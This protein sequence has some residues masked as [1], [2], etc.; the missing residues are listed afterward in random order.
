MVSRNSLREAE[1]P[2]K[3]TTIAYVL[4]CYSLGAGLRGLIRPLQ[5]KLRTIEFLIS[6]IVISL[7][8]A[9]FLGLNYNVRIRKSLKT[10]ALIIKWAII[11][12]TCSLPN[13]SKQKRSVLVSGLNTLVAL[14]KGTDCKSDPLR[15][16]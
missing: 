10:L 4:F 7:Q 14:V 3:Q 8:K 1:T 9:E 2:R 11:Q 12:S 5:T 6:V 13:D 15:Q 16:T